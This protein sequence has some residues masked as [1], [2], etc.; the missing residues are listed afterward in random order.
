MQITHTSHYQVFFHTYEVAGRMWPRIFSRI[1]VGL[2]LFEIMSSGLFLLRKA[3]PL[4]ALCWPLIFLTIGFKLTMD[5]AYLRS[6]RVLP[7]Q[8]LTQRLGTAETSVVDPSVVARNNNSNTTNDPQPSSSERTTRL[9]FARDLPNR[10]TLRR[11]RTVLDQDDYVAAP[12]VH[13]DFRQPPMTLVD[14]ILNTGMKKYGHPALL[15]HLPHLWLPVASRNYRR[16]S[17]YS[18][19]LNLCG[20]SMA[21]KP[22]RFLSNGSVCSSPISPVDG[23]SSLLSVGEVDTMN[24]NSNNERQPLL[25]SSSP[26]QQTGGILQYSD[27]RQE[28]VL[29]EDEEASSVDTSS[30]EEDET[31]ARKMYYHHPERRSRVVLPN[32]FSSTNNNNKN[33]GYG[34]I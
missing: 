21:T 1:I 25:Y 28:Q 30:S 17:H 6:T 4:A 18:D 3:Y 12:T 9:S 26:Q 29:L 7:L 16:S 32:S 20:T 13:T 5:A 31:A 33:S 24:N 27:G 14:G 23:D 2:L 10:T 15:G 11:R 8:L 34:A 22:V 19:D